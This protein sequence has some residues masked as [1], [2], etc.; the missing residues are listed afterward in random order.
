MVQFCD[1]ADIPKKVPGFFAIRS[2][3]DVTEAGHKLSDFEF[4][5][6][7]E[8][9]DYVSTGSRSFGG[10]E[11]SLPKQVLGMVLARDQQGVADWVLERAGNKFSPITYHVS[12]LNLFN[13]AINVEV[14][15]AI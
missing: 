13:V 12:K 2:F 4:V 10:S 15:N 9:K 11:I 1:S 6:L 5:I 7:T 3:N 14:S 8:H